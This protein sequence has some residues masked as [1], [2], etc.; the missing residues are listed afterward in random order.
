MSG[1]YHP[2]LVTASSVPKFVQILPPMFIV[3]TMQRWIVRGMSFGAV[4]G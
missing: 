3:T 1:C 2:G 4:K